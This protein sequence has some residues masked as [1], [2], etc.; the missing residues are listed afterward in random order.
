MRQIGAKSR[1]VLSSLSPTPAQRWEDDDDDDDDDDDG[2]DD[3]DDVHP[4]LTNH[5]V[6]CHIRSLRPNAGHDDNERNRFCWLD[7]T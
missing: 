1:I 7:C 6:C 3:D 2:V 4:P 5:V